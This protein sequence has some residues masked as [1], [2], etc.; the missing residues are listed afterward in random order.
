MRLGPSYPVQ[1]PPTPSG[2]F[3]SQACTYIGTLYK[4]AAH[5]LHTYKG[6]GTQ[7]AKIRLKLQVACAVILPTTQRGTSARSDGGRARVR[8]RI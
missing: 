4:H 7:G 1:P 6:E 5:L 8:L 2:V 3:A